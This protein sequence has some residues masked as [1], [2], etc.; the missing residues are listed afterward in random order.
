VPAR[1]AAGAEPGPSQC[2]LVFLLCAGAADSLERAAIAC[3]RSLLP[4][5]CFPPRR[6][7]CF[8]Q[9]AAAFIGPLVVAALTSPVTRRQV[10][11][12]VLVC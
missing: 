2:F 3:N 7:T 11:R 10:L 6:S 9:A 12:D 4:P 5:Q 8:E 1:V